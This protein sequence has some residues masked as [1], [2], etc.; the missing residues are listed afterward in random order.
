MV[1]FLNLILTFL[2]RGGIL[3]G[4]KCPD[5]ERLLYR[6]SWDAVPKWVVCAELLQ[7][8][9]CAFLGEFYYLGDYYEKR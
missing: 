4:T 5:M 9:G 2:G 8:R 1:I 6:V 7:V 3:N